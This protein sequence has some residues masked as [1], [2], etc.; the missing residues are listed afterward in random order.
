MEQDSLSYKTIKNAGY[1]FIN[2]AFPILFSVFITPVVVRLLGV[3]DF[4]VYVLVNTIIGFL[5]LLD[6]GL[7]TALVKFIAEYYGRKYFLGLQKLINSAN[8]LF[9]IIGLVSFL[10]LLGIGAFFLPLFNIGLGSEQHIFVV[11]FLAGI[12]SFLNAINS[13]YSIV[14][15]ALLRFDINAKT[16]LAQLTFFNLTILLAVLLGFKLKAILALNLISVIF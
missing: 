1:T 11:F 16:S 4:G 9:L 10:A 6:L 7:S 8:S 14:T 12:L 5:G 13:I 3:E 2:Y 15:A